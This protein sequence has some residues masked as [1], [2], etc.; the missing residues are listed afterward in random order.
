MGGFSGDDGVVYGGVSQEEVF[1]VFLEGDVAEVEEEGGGLVAFVLDGGDGPLER[2]DEGCPRV[3]GS[4]RGCLVLEVW[5]PDESGV[6]ELDGEL[7]VHPYQGDAGRPLVPRLGSFGRDRAPRGVG[8]FHEKRDD[9]L[10]WVCRKGYNQDMEATVCSPAPTFPQPYRS[11]VSVTA[12]GVGERKGYR[13]T[14]VFRPVMEDMWETAYHFALFASEEEAEAFADR[15][16]RH[17]LEGGELRPD[18]WRVFGSAASPFGAEGLGTA[19][20]EKEPRAPLGF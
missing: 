18:C 15:V 8:H 13:A 7:L 11:E 19:E 2:A 1:G 16:S 9:A 4:R 17:C 6:S 14:F 20:L 12:A 10:D 3:F 5:C